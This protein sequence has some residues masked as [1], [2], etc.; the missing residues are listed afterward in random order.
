MNPTSLIL[1]KE[2]FEHQVSLQELFFSRV[3]LLLNCKVRCVLL[4][5]YLLILKCDLS[6]CL[7][8]SFQTLIPRIWLMNYCRRPWYF[9]L[10][11]FFLHIN[12]NSTIIV[13]L[14]SL[15]SL[16][17]FCQEFFSLL[18]LVKDL[19]EQK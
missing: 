2:L 13:V 7:H 11:S 16:F 12:A 5:V 9:L 6:R 4:F 14:R 8:F 18:D 1:I 3:M 17:I 19:E 15:L 10:S